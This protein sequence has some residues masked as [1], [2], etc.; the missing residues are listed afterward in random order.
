VVGRP[1]TRWGELVVAVVVPRPGASLTPAAVMARLDGRIARY[2]QPK[3]VFIVDAL[4]RTALGKVRKEDVRALV[5][6]LA[7]EAATAPLSR[8]STA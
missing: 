1:D 2:K 7:D 5:A 4:P 6:R 8:E 3:Q